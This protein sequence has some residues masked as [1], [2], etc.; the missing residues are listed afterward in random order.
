MHQNLNFLKAHDWSDVTPILQYDGKPP[1]LGIK[2]NESYQTMM[3][4]FRAIINSK[5]VSERVWA[6]TFEVIDNLPSN[7]NVWY[8]RRK[9]IKEL[10]KDLKKEL[11]FIN[12]TIEGNEKTYQI[13]EHRRQIVELYGSTEH[14]EA[15]FKKV[16]DVDNKNYHAWS[17]RIWLC[18][19]F[20]LYES[21]LPKVEYYLNEDIGN[22]SAWNYRFFLMK[23]KL[24]DEELK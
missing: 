1:I 11:E 16:F 7:Y 4:Y 6:L 20:N 14:E 9:C 22:N 21:E 23:R 19:K 13:W 2:Y 3:N 12:E 5:E 17:Y 15:F 8:V 18:Q 10:K 24:T